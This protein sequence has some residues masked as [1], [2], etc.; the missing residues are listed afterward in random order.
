MADNSS[1][2]Y[3]FSTFKLTA[4]IAGEIVKDIVSFS[5]TF[6]LNT[7]PTASMVMAC[8]LNATTNQPASIHKL[9]KKLKLRDPVKVYLDVDTR[10]GK[11]EKSPSAKMLIFEGY[12]SGFGFQRAQDNA[13]YTLHLVHW[14]DDLNVGSM[15]SR[16]IFP[17]AP[18]DFA[19]SAN[20]GSGTDAGAGAAFAEPS[21]DPTHQY[22]NASNIAKDFWGDAIKPAFKKLA[23]LP[24]PDNGCPDAEEEK[25]PDYQV[26]IDALDK[27]PGK[28]PNPGK[29]PLA[30]N[31]SNL[32]PDQLARS[33][34]NA[35]S[36]TGIMG[37]NYTTYW[38]VLLGSWAPNF[39]FAISPGVEF[40]NMI[41]FFSGLKWQ[42]GGY[43]KTI[44]ADEYGYA[45]FMANTS[46]ILEGIN[47]FWNQNF[48]KSGITGGTEA[49]R[50][51]TRFCDPLGSFPPKN[52]R[53]H[54]GTVLVKEAPAW[55]AEYLQP[56][57]YV[58]DSTGMQLQH[59]G[60][61][62][63]PWWGSA[64][65]SGGKELL[66]ELQRQMKNSRLLDKF[67]EQWYK[68]EVLQQRY[69]E[70]SGKLRF[71]I[72]PGSTI[73]IKAAR[74]TMPA[75]TDHVDM[76]ATVVKV[77]FVI[78]A[79][80]ASAGTAFTLSNIRSEFEN[81]NPLLTSDKPAI[82]EKG[83]AGGPLVASTVAAIPG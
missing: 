74:K 48:E 18:F 50:P 4:E 7:I 68:N 67:A 31:G 29:L 20:A 36:H 47:I 9:A 69:G 83:W 63:I 24:Q 33:I 30:I 5:G 41:P 17:G 60:D 66:A 25:G 22:F 78:N 53:D 71:D 14:L 2:T 12:Y 16:R 43:F 6:A 70:M 65:P 8:G 52:L 49:R 28:A 51:T 81:D 79:E 75:L 1:D 10:D 56:D 39:M 15:L 19:E 58:P 77:S 55:I 21:L 38:S 32:D 80:Q 44:E 73:K 42:Q 26:I 62:S 64:T 40:A 82:Y 35:V 13:Q 23:E 59:I 3:V 54:R 46:Q 72:A 37:F 76:I 34:H 45:N 57:A 27:I 11:K 61:T